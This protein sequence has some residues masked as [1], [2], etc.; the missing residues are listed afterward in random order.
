[1]ADPKDEKKDRLFSDIS[2]VQVIATALASVT[3]MLLASYIGIAGSVIG[4]AVASIVSTLAASAYKKFLRDSAEKIKELP[5]PVVHDKLAAHDGD[6]G[7]TG[8]GDSNDDASTAAS[9]DEARRSDDTND[10]PDAE[11]TRNDHEK[12][13]YD[14]RVRRLVVI[15]AVSALLAVA[16]S[17]AA[18]YFLTTGQGLGAK[19][20]PIAVTLHDSLSH[21]TEG[22]GGS[23]ASPSS[24]ASS[25]ASSAS[26]SASDSSSAAD[27]AESSSSASS[28]S[29][30]A[31]DATSEPAQPSSPSVDEGAGPDLE[32]AQI[33][34]PVQDIPPADDNG[35]GND[36]A[37]D[38]A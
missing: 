38:S 34:G 35:D 16:A 5:I 28:A 32:G 4:V 11:A 6:Q 17:G 24:A 9:N 12:R 37:S 29:S 20:A 2:P 22:S 3:S 13:E 18:V 10:T 21:R 27:S 26:S 36:G 19:P 25:E 15:C 8:Q 31:S 33:S 14:K 7:D 23:Q 30:Q 1:M